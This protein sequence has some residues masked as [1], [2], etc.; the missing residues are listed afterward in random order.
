MSES[1]AAKDLFAAAMSYAKARGSR[2]PDRISR[3]A[4][5]LKVL[6]RRY[7]DAYRDHAALT[8]AAEVTDSRRQYVTNV[9]TRMLRVW[10]P[11]MIG[12]LMAYMLEHGLNRS[13]ATKEAVTDAF[14]TL[15][16]M[17]QTAALDDL[18]REAAQCMAKT[19]EA[20]E[21]VR[22]DIDRALRLEPLESKRPNKEGT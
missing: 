6:A 15:L 10:D 18:V 2:K 9:L 20:N 1:A 3:R 16:T 21:A 7:A 14:T 12:A 8:Y 13:E 19:I 4:H 5:D 11:Q 17:V 22:K